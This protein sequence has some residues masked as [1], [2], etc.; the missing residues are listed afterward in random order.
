[1]ANEIWKRPEIQ[2]EEFFASQFQADFLREEGFQV[3]QDVAGMNTAFVAEWGE[4]KP[5]IG[6]IG[7]YDALPGLSQKAQPTQEPV[8]TG[9]HGH[10]CG[11]NMLGTAPLAAAVATQKLLAR[12]GLKGTVRYYGCPAEEGGGGKVFMARDG[13]F[14]DLDAALTWHPDSVNMPGKGSAVAINDIVFR[15]KGRASHA[16]S[17]PHLGRSAL[18]AVELMNVGANYLREHVRDG[19]RIQYVITDGGAAANIVPETAAVHYILRAEKVDDLHAL[20]ERVQKIAEGAAMMTETS[21]EVKQGVGYANLMPNHYLADLLFEEMNAIGPIDFTAQEIAFAQEVNDSFPG[22][23]EEYLRWQIDYLNPDKESRERWLRDRDLPLIGDNF[24]AM[25]EGVTF[26]WATDVGD[27]SQ[28][29]PTGVF[30]AACFTTGSPGHSWGNVATGGMSIGHKGM[31]HAA[32]TM[33]LT[34]YE[35]LGNPEHIKNAQAEFDEMMAGKKYEP[36]I[37]LDM[38]PPRKQPVK[39]I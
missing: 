7:E 16:G 24:P 22:T 2:W 21:L 6:F 26:K 12:T 9:G 20:T 18:D 27:L 14:D 10:G 32:K 36:Q 8:E 33:A 3:T 30:T 19:T 37:P 15:F 11:H 5:V 23:N 28:I 34:A 31:M 38:N 25:D 39:A 35:L 1:M 17:S 4:G 13:M 29:T